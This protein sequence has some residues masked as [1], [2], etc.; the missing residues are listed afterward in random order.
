MSI[1]NLRKE[2]HLDRSGQISRVLARHGLDYLAGSLGLEG[3]AATKKLLGHAGHNAV[4]TQP[5]HLR[6]AL[7]ELGTTFIKLGQIISTR[8]DLLP[9][10]YLVELTKLQDAAPSVPFEAIQ[11]AVVREL[12]RP[13][14]SVFAFFDPEPLAA[15]SI[16]QAHAATLPDGT[17]VVVKVRRPGVVEQVEEDLEILKRLAATATRHWEF[18]SRYDLVGLAQEFSDT[19]RS[20]LDYLREGQNAETFATNFAG[21]PKIHIPRI[22]W[23]TTTSKV[24]TM[25]RIR[26][27]KINDLEALDS[28]RINRPALAEYATRVILKM[29][30]DDGFFHADPHPGNFFIEADG[31]IGLIDFGMVGKVDEPTQQLLADLLVN[32]SKENADRLVDVFLELGVARRRVNRELLRRDVEHLLTVYWGRQL[33]DVKIAALLN[34]VFTIMRNHRLHLPPNLALLLKTV[35]MIEGL[36]TNLDPDFQF[37][38]VLGPYTQRLVLRQYSPALWI[39]RFGSASIDLARLG[40]ELP[41]QLRRMLGAIEHGN[42]QI[43]ARPEGFD[44]LIDRFERISNRIVLGVIAAAFINGLAVLLSVYRPPAWEKWAW[45]IFAFGFLCALMLGVYLAWSILLSKRG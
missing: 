40:V 7:E 44:P 25:E 39:P 18:A 6:M 21:D 8:A 37:A 34:D 10:E 11:Q 15:A 32:I 41:Q 5:E 23:D 12:G 30:C 33:K 27:I 43:G 17:E 35:I 14:E 9:P 3:F 31:R 22:F 2:L 16:G 20:E 13:L 36:G 19:L 1:V 45:A 29:V 24:L 42:L 28:Q 38:R 4:L 26:G